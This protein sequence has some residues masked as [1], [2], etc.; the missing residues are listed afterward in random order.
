[1]I[2]KFP[3]GD[4]VLLA[5][6]ALLARW[7]LRSGEEMPEPVVRDKFVPIPV[8]V[9]VE[10]ILWQLTKDYDLRHIRKMRNLLNERYSELED[11]YRVQMPPDEV[12]KRVE[13]MLAGQSEKIAPDPPQ[14]LATLQPTM[15]TLALPM[16]VPAIGSK[17]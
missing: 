3:W 17:T 2:G 14:D 8:P 12:A 11:C 6:G 4:L 16:P 7:G 1:M 10:R 5:G 9:Y 15:M 13:N